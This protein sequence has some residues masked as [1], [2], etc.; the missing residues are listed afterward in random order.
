MTTTSTPDLGMFLLAHQALRRDAAAVAAAARRVH[1]QSVAD[2]TELLRAFEVFDAMLRHHHT[3]EDDLVWPALEAARPA[4]A[5]EIEDLEA[6]HDVAERWLAE[7]RLALRTLALPYA[8]DRAAVAVDL[9]VAATALADELDAHL[10]H[11]ERI[12]V[13]LIADA[14][15]Q[16]QWLAIDDERKARMSPEDTATSLAWILSVLPE[17]E[18]DAIASAK[19]PAPVVSMWRSEWAPAYAERVAALAA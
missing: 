5:A 15:S 4:C 12:A 11:E 9:I 19:L 18:R 10:V 1:P 13:P 3:A 2:A 14:L 6:E 16:E 7:V 17:S 8:P